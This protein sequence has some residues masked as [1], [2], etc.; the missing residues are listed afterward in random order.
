MGLADPVKNGDYVYA[1][2][3]TDTNAFSDAYC[4]FDSHVISA[5]E[6]EKVELVLSAAGWDANWSP[7]TVPV[8]DAVITVDG[9]ETEVRTNAQGKAVLT[10][11]KG[12]HLISASSDEQVLV[13]PVCMAEVTAKSGGNVPETDDQTPA[14]GG[15]DAMFVVWMSLFGASAIGLIALVYTTKKKVYEK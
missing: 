8:A 6:G 14:T 4:Y 12:T 11:T 5:V 2:V 7:I 13:P 9:I 1:F 10:L 15:E 3:Y